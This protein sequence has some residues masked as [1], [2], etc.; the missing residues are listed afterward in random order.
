MKKN[1]LVYTLLCIYTAT[2]TQHLHSSDLARIGLTA[3]GVVTFGIGVN[4]I[5][6]NDD[7]IFGSIKST[8]K[9][10]VLITL[11]GAII[12]LEEWLYPGLAGF[13]NR[14]FAHYLG[15]KQKDE[16]NKPQTQEQTT[17]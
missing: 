9:G 1:I 4:T 10:A 6:K 17:T 12:V 7:S 11:G 3:A 14:R 13:L 2:L 15:I 5:A 16:I 8:V